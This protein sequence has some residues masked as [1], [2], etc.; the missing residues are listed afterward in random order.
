M[1]HVSYDHILIVSCMRMP[2]LILHENKIA[3]NNEVK[4][5]A[6]S[7]HSFKHSVAAQPM[8]SGQRSNYRPKLSYLLCQE[9]LYPQCT[10]QIHSI[11]PI[12]SSH[13]G[14][15]SSRHWEVFCQ[16]FQVKH[17]NWGISFPFV[18]CKKTDNIRGTLDNEVGI[19]DVQS[20]WFCRS[21]LK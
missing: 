15:P 12:H 13:C 7:K 3:V 2:L 1:Y 18:D 8:W 21:R 17:A 14:P 6:S 5:P 11:L 9:L 20:K 16:N 10:W 4:V 19:T